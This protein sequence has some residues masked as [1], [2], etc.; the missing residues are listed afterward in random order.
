MVHIEFARG[1]KEN[2]IPDVQLTRSKDESNGRAFFYF[3][4]PHALEEG[5]RV[6]MRPFAV[7]T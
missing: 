6:W 7:L 1:V 4:N 2:V 3:Q 5:F